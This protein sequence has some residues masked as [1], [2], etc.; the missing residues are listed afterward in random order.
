MKW[1]KLFRILQKYPIRKIIAAKQLIDTI[2]MVNEAIDGEMTFV[3]SVENNESKFSLTTKEN[4]GYLNF[5]DIASDLNK[6]SKAHTLTTLNI[7]Q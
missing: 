5:M 2:S 7:L 4:I 1:I 3:I 6:I